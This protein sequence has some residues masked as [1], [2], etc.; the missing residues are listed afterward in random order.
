MTVVIWHLTPTHYIPDCNMIKWLISERKCWRNAEGH[1]VL[2]GSGFVLCL[3][4]GKHLAEHIEE[5]HRHN[6]GQIISGQFSSNIKAQ[7]IYNIAPL[8]TLTVQIQ[9]TYVSSAPPWTLSAEPIMTLQLMKEEC[10]NALE[11]ELLALH[12]KQVF[13]GVEIL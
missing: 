3:I 11:Q 6:P 2:P 4:P 5:W 7:F 9:S 13:D 8:L 1:V 12:K 10:I